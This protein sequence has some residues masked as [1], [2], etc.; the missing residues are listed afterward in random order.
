MKK[1]AALCILAVSF[2]PAQTPTNDDKTLLAADRAFIEAASKFD[3]K[4]LETLLD[5][6]FTW[7]TQQGTTQSRKDSLQGKMTFAIPNESAAQMHSYWYGQVGVVQA[8]LARAH[9]LR[10]WVK[11]AGAW[12]LLVYQEL[13]SLETPPTFS[14]AAGKDCE[15]PC[16]HIPFRPSNEAE[17][18]VA[19]SYSKLETAAT[20]K[21]SAAFGMLVG[22]EFIA[23]SSYSNKLSTKQDRMNDFDH[24]KNGGVAPTPLMSARMFAFGDAV[25]MKSEHTPDRG[26]P[27]HVTRM[28]VK[29]D[30][31][32]VETLSY[33]TAVQ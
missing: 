7:T 10:V 25:V 22:D 16:K 19:I 30:G 5:D 3:G 21:N 27:L 12:K 6:D 9:E 29:R 20:A 31:N 11:R 14:P 2:L 18:D 17:R 24:A 4:T 33:Q 13:I 23:A 26:N 15:N 8:D 28:W 1:A 32:W